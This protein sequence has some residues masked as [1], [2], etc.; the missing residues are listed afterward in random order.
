MEWGGLGEADLPDK[1]EGRDGVDEL[2]SLE[3]LITVKDLRQ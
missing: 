2:N 3:I 1:R